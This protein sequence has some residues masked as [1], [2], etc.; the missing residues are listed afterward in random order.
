MDMPSIISTPEPSDSD[1][2]SK[3][4]IAGDP[5]ALRIFVEQ[6]ANKLTLYVYKLVHK[7]GTIEDAKDIVQNTF[8]IVWVKSASHYNQA[9]GSLITWTYAIARNMAVTFLRKEKA[10]QANILI[11]NKSEK[12]FEDSL[13]IEEYLIDK[14][15]HSAIN[16][17]IQN[18]PYEQKQAIE[19]RYYHGY[20]LDQIAVHAKCPKETVKTR[21]R[22]AK[23]LI[24]Q[25]YIN[26][27]SSN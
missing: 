7:W 16:H 12:V 11:E 6:H 21:L 27:C 22:R 15:N 13:S 20:S 2:V 18:L 17:L 23:K 19:L 8:V 24:R 4:I 10:R 9:R 3:R 14:G 1:K 25:Q 26:N 5:N